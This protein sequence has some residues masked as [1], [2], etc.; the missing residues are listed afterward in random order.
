MGRGT[1]RG[2]VLG[3]GG[4]DGFGRIERGARLTPQM[5]NGPPGQSIACWFRVVVM[6][7]P[8]GEP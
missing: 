3:T 7:A 5:Q 2:G 4:A 8:Y 6:V 1:G